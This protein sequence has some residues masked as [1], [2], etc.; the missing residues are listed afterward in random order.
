MIGSAIDSIFLCRYTRTNDKNLQKRKKERKKKRKT[1]KNYFS[2]PL[3]KKFHYPLSPL[4]LNNPTS[5]PLSDRKK[6]KKK[7][8]K[9]ERERERKENPTKERNILNNNQ[10]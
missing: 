10:L 4:E 8:K 9:K 6:K 7:K 1:I 2:L 5:S 3:D